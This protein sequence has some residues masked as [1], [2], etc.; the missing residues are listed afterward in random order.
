MGWMSK[1]STRNNS[2]E[3]RSK[4]KDR[5]LKDQQPSGIKKE[6][7]NIRSAFISRCGSFDLT[8]PVTPKKESK[9]AEGLSRRLF[10][11]HWKIGSGAFGKVWKVEEK[12]SHTIYA[13]K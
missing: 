2:V 10:K 8:Q 12:K 7:K 4:S 11:F 1:P 3:K 6:S 13:M 9:A 5:I